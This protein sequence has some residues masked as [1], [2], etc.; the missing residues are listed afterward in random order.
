MD[1]DQ[2]ALLLQKTM[3]GRSVQLRLQKGRARKADLINEMRV[4]NPITQ[5][6]AKEVGIEQITIANTVILY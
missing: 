3:R 6:E 2:A 5:E 4:E 1:E